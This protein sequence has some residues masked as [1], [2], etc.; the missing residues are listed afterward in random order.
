MKSAES[1]PGWLVKL[2][3]GEELPRDLVAAASALGAG[4]ASVQGIG[5]VDRAVIAWFDLATK[6]L[7][8][9]G[10]S[11]SRWRSSR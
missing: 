8:R 6:T 3:P 9:D 5:A 7:R 4:T 10:A 11:T 1:A 2:E